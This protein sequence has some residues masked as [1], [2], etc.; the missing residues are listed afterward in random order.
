M[1]HCPKSNPD[2]RDITRNVEEKRD[3]KGN[4]RRSISFPPHFVLYIGKSGQ[5]SGVMLKLRYEEVLL[6]SQE[7]EC[8]LH[9]VQSVPHLLP[10]GKGV[11]LNQQTLNKYMMQINS[12]LDI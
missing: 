12:L 11:L 10:L 6:F 2:F 5:F 7:P 3:T 1:V 8:P 4:I 9:L